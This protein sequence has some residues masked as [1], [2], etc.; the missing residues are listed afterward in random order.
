MLLP[1]KVVKTVLLFLSLP[2]SATAAEITLIDQFSEGG[3]PLL[4][5]LGLSILFLSVTIERLR[6]FRTEAIV[7]EGLVE[8]IKPMWEMRDYAA[9]E[10]LLVTDDST[11]AR[12]IH[13]IITHREQG[14]AFLNR[15]AGDIASMELRQH[16]QKAYALAIVATVAPIVGLVGTVL[17]MIEAFNVIAYADGMGNAVLLAGGI[18][19]AL[20]NTAAGLTVALLALG[21]HHFLK[22]RMAIL[23]LRLEKQVNRLLNEWFVPVP[24]SSS[25]LKGVHHAH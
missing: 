4:V 21:M 24:A 22:H 20:V 25:G 15:G 13:Y 11:L 3:I 1:S 14:F 9:I 12:V 16:Q 5:I 8:R 19:K 18:S 17:G 7:P 23:G 2:V 6:H 10:Q